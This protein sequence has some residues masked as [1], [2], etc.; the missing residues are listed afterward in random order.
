MAISLSANQDLMARILIV[1]IMIITMVTLTI[2][3]MIVNK[4]T[5]TGDNDKR[6]DPSSFHAL[7]F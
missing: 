3:T 2:V 5:R 1:V 4:V 6:D 7:R